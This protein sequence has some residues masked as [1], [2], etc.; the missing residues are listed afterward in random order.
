MKILIS[1]LLILFNFQLYGQS[2]SNSDWILIKSELKSDNSL[3]ANLFEEKGAIKYF[4]G[5]NTVRV[6]TSDLS[7]IEMPFT[8]DGNSLNIGEFVK[9][10]IDSSDGQVMVLSDINS[11]TAENRRQKFTFLKMEYLFDLLKQLDYLML[12]SDS[13]IV[14][15]N[16]ISPVYFGD[17]IAKTLSSKFRAENDK[18]IYLGNILISPEGNV[19]DVEVN[20][21]KK[22]YLGEL[23]SIKSVLKS[24]SGFWKIPKTPSRY[25]F[26]L[27]FIIQVNYMKPL[28]GVNISLHP[29]IQKK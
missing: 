3:I 14:S 9:Y 24:T 1:V 21:N 4:F 12:D 8:Q 20:S 2:V 26:K 25:F 11:K 5:G 10:S 22:S 7:Y 28:I 23:S 19:I 17:D 16:L 15:S 6:F 18:E 27:Y 29:K 13:I